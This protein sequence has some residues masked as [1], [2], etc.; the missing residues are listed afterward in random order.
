M[1]VVPNLR[2]SQTAAGRAQLEGALQF[3]SGAPSVTIEEPR[4]PTAVLSMKEINDVTAFITGTPVCSEAGRLQRA[5][6]SVSTMAPESEV[7][8]PGV[9]PRITEPV[10]LELH[11]ALKSFEQS[12]D[13]E[14]S[15][16][17]AERADARYKLG[18]VY[19]NQTD[20]VE[21]AIE[22][23]FGALALNPRHTD[24]WTG[25]GAALLQEGHRE[26][27]M[28]ALRTALSL[29]SKHACAHLHLGEALQQQFVLDVA[30]ES[31]AARLAKEKL[32]EL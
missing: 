30:P 13:K 27:A 24:A 17:D 31:D 18:F 12:A 8:S 9:S 20:E 6:T 14:I 7:D 1:V 26:G 15:S 22:E 2:L 25:L 28:K 4:K 29:S 3:I 32:E 21:D 10:L 5:W 11:N 16:R 23:F 19:A